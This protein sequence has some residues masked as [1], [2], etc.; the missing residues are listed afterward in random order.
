MLNT[1]TSKAFSRNY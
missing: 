1:M